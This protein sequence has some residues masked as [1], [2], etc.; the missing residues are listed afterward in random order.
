MARYKSNAPQV[1]ARLKKQIQDRLSLAGEFVETAAAL[2]SPVGKTGNLRASINHK[3][4]APF[5]ERVGT[6]VEYAPY[7]ELGTRFMRARPYLLPALIDN[8]REIRNIL[9]GK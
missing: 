7:V 3:R 8:R 4:S 6:A 5:I 9:I 1:E 2:N